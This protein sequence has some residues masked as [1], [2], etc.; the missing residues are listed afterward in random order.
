MVCMPRGVVVVV[1][2][3]D[4]GRSPRMQYHALSLAD[5]ASRQVHVVAYA[6]ATP[7][8]AV[9]Q[10]EHI[11]LHVLPAPPALPAWLP[12]PLALAVKAVW[13]LLGLLVALLWRTP[14][15][16]HLLLQTPPC[17]PTFLACQVACAL[18]RTRLVCDWHNFGFSLLALS[19]P[20]GS[21]LL[22]LAER[23]ERALGRRA[24]AHL[25]VTR[26]MARELAKPGWGVAGA[27][28]LH[29]RP[30]A[31]F[32]RCIDVNAQHGLFCRLAPAL[33]SSPAASAEDWCSCE[34]EGARS[35]GRKNDCRQGHSRSP[36]CADAS[37]LRTPFTRRAGARAAAELRADRPALVVRSAAQRLRPLAPATRALTALLF[38]VP[39]R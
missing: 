23:Y 18:R 34:G 20:P 31:Q 17:V 8:A 36:A 28:V 9:A 5:Q 11:T 2:L 12:R 33:V 16:T 1:V 26:A 27:V 22:R 35:L 24:H 10:H 6:G 29:D 25:C 14:A 39:L 15:A 37:P 30:A 38:R 7:V 19:L 4:W 21:L 3:G 32:R 13:Q